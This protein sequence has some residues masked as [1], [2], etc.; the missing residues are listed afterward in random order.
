MTMWQFWP[1]IDQENSDGECIQHTIIPHTIALRYIQCLM[2]KIVNRHI[3]LLSQIIFSQ[4][5]IFS[6][7]HDRIWWVDRY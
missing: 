3:G 5:V 4:L 2:A 1:K 6:L 7:E